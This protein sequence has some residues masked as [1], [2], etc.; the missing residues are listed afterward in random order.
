M[1]I[2]RPLEYYKL[3]LRDAFRKATVAEID[4]LTA[5]SGID[6]EANRELCRR[7]REA[8]SL[9]SAA[10]SRAGWITFL[11]VIGWIAVVAALAVAIFQDLSSLDLQ[12]RVGLGVAAALVAAILIWKVH[13]WLKSAQTERDEQAAE[14]QRLIAEAQAQMQAMNSLYDWDIFSR[15]AA[16]VMPGIEFDPFVTQQRIDELGFYGLATHLG[17]D[18]AV[19]YAHSGAIFGSPFVLCKLRSQMWGQRTYHG[20]ITISWSE[21]DSNG[22]WQRRSQVLTASVTKPY[23]EFPSRTMLI[24]GNQAAPDLVFNRRKNEADNFMANTVKKWK[25]KRKARDME[26]DFAMSTN[27]DFEVLFYTPD[28]NDNQQFFLL[29]T[30]LAQESMIELLRDDKLGYGD[31]FDFLKDQRITTIVPDHVQNQILDMDPAQF[32]SHDYDHA[33]ELF[34][35]R[36]CEYFRS[37]YFALAPLL[38]VPM[39]Q[40]AHPLSGDKRMMSSSEWERESLAYYWGED[41]FRS[42][43]CVTPCILKT[44]Q[45]GD[46]VTVNALGFT[47][48]RR[49]DYVSVWGGDGR[50]HRVPVEWDEYLPVSGQGTYE[51]H[52]RPGDQQPDDPNDRAAAIRDL[53]ERTARGGIFRRHIVSRL[54]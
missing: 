50:T 53:I 18:T 45:A 6:I 21:R 14:A 13:P 31:D 10:D 35:S 20:S 7:I 4:S 42:P 44:R 1:E 11:L 38:C 5:A 34:I 15:L 47:A 22:R 43:N 26:S 52:E 40:Q 46:R 39:Y 24:F 9:R 37:V 8:E 16:K 25:L 49:V 33:R 41:H 28:R 27:E 30:P 29:F 3:H 51:M 36:M 19:L 17:T 23:P 48:V 12:R 2:F 54:R 32:I